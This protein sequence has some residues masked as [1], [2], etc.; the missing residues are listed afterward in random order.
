M[1][2][3]ITVVQAFVGCP[4]S[5]SA[6]LQDSLGHNLLGMVSEEVRACQSQVLFLVGSVVARAS[7]TEDV[8]QHQKAAVDTFANPCFDEDSVEGAAPS[9]VGHQSRTS[10]THCGALQAVAN[11]KRRHERRSSCARSQNSASRVV[12]QHGA[13]PVRMTASTSRGRRLWLC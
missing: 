8:T 11:N 5:A 7:A 3:S 13:G 2:L 6:S 10:T 12:R 4:V 9:A 1:W